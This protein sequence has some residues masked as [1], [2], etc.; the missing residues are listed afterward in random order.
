[1]YTLQR[2]LQQAKERL[3]LSVSGHLADSVAAT[4]PPAAPVET[5]DSTLKAPPRDEGQKG[6]PLESEEEDR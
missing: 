5:V 6:A 4:L 2:F 1:M 3:G